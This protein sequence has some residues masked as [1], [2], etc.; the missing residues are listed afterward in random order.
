MEIEI[1]EDEFMEAVV[2]KNPVI[3]VLARD[4][5]IY[6]YTDVNKKSSLELILLLTQ[7]AEELC[8]NYRELLGADYIKPTINLHINSPGGLYLSCMAI[9]DTMDRLKKKVNINTYVEGVA[10][11]AATM[12]SIHGTKRF[13]TKNS[14]ML[15]H[16]VSAGTIGRYSDMLDGIQ[17]V[18]S[19]MKQMVSMYTEKTNISADE[20]HE[21]LKH[22]LFWVAD[23]CLSKG[24][25]DE[26]EQ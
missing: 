3:E 8:E 13:I 11:S 5:D 20:I 17:N 7:T 9:I 18:D 12:I 26:I 16:E 22:D 15:I 21:L 1:M 14:Y 25:V 2:E 24:L 4:N 19:F 6:F 23:D 10:A